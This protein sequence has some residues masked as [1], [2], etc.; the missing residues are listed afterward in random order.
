MFVRKFMQHRGYKVNGG[1]S[2]PACFY[3]GYFSGRMHKTLLEEKISVE[4]DLLAFKGCSVLRREDGN[5][6]LG[7]AFL[8]GNF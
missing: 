3:M 2:P 1:P 5:L 8:W 6:G 7:A 4:N